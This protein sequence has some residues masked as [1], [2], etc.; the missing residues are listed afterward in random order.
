VHAVHHQREL[1]HRERKQRIGI[2]RD[3]DRPVVGAEQDRVLVD[4]P[5]RRLHAEAGA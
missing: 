2:G 1:M 5:L 4:D 3:L